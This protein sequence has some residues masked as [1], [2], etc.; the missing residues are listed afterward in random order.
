MGGKRLSGFFIGLNQGGFFY[1]Q[2]VSG[3][4]PINRQPEELQLCKVRNAAQGNYSHF[5]LK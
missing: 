2:K 4:L 1:G 5:V 3:Q